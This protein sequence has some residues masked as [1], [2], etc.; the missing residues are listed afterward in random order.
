M[1]RTRPHPTRP[2]T[3]TT[4]P[5]PATPLRAWLATLSA[6]YDGAV[7]RDAPPAAAHTAHT[8]HSAQIAPPGAAAQHA[9]T[10][11]LRAWCTR[12][13]GDGRAPLWRPWALPEL[14]EA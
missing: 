9:P 11:A 12:G 13:S 14:P 4:A 2:V 3:T 5:R 10:A 8:A 7:M 1:G 6:R